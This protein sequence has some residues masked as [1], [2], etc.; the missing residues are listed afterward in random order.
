MSS[1]PLLFS[2]HKKKQMEKR[3]SCPDISIGAFFA[4]NIT[5]YSIT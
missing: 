3:R 5:V 4:L 2:N 1:D